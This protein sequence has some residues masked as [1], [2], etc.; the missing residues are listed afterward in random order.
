M[1]HCTTSKWADCTKFY[2]HL[3]NKEMDAARSKR[4]RPKATLGSA[5]SQEVRKLYKKSCAKVKLIV[6]KAKIEKCST[7]C[8]KL[9]LRQDGINRKR[10]ITEDKKKAEHFNRYFGLGTEQE[11]S[12]R[13]TRDACPT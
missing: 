12:L 10:T 3:Y 11:N 8:A 13:V 4:K 1:E 5:P 7:T 9:D 6:M 2:K